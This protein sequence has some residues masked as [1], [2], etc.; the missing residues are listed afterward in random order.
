MSE[1]N[2]GQNIDIKLSSPMEAAAGM[3]LGLSIKTDCRDKDGVVKEIRLVNAEGNYSGSRKDGEIK[4]ST[5]TINDIKS[6]SKVDQKNEE[7]NLVKRLLPIFNT[8]NSTSFNISDE[9]TVESDIN[10]IF[11]KDFNTGKK[12][13]IQVTA[14][15]EAIGN[16]KRPRSFFSR[17]GNEYDIFSQ[18]IKMRIKAKSFYVESERRKTILAL[19]GWPGVAAEFLYKFKKQERSCLEK[20]CYSQVWFVGSDE[21]IIIRLY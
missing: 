13:G 7:R 5:Q 10:D 17:H 1:K 6:K 18:A 4:E 19:D 2:E 8:E 14:S 20:A 15:D 12:I 21:E 16:L 9:D 3:P 11:I